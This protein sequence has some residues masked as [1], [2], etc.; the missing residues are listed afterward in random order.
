MACFYNKIL[1]LVPKE[2]CEKI[3]HKVNELPDIMDHLKDA[4]K[5][6]YYLRLELSHSV[7]TYLTWPKAQNQYILLSTVF[8]FC[9]KPR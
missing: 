5:T 2:Q 3:D 9:F 8:P 1:V 7:I 6:E 4:Y